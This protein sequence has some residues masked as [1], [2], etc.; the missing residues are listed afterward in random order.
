LHCLS[1]GQLLSVTYLL[2]SVQFCVE[3]R[4]ILICQFDNVY[5]CNSEI[6]ASGSAHLSWLW[7]RSISIQ[8]PGIHLKCLCVPLFCAFYGTLCINQ[9]RSLAGLKNAA[10]LVLSWLVFSTLSHK[11]EYIFGFYSPK[12]GV[13]IGHNFPP[14]FWLKFTSS[15]FELKFTNPPPF[16]FGFSAFLEG[17]F[18]KNVQWKI[19]EIK[20][21]GSFV[22]GLDCEA[23]NK[24]EVLVY[25]L[26][27]PPPI[28]HWAQAAT[29]R[30]RDRSHWSHWTLLTKSMC[31]W[32]MLALSN[33]AYSRLENFLKTEKSSS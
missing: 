4:W 33:L 27:H 10:K 2:L 3:F 17:S 20:I 28:F 6:F 30:Y 26:N 8:V 31:L 13:K 9:K 12:S 23:K 18:I 29:T 24:G 32:T 19:M 21:R 1:S 5:S 15:I 11:Q 7:S 14:T 22:N 16:P 25:T